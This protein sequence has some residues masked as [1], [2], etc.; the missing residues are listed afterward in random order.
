MESLSEL[1]RQVR[2]SKGLTLEDMASKTRIN[3]DFLEALE[4]GNFARLPDQVFAKGFV[5]AYARSLGLDEGEALR[6]FESAAGVFYEKQTETEQLRAKQVEEARRKRANRNVVI[7]AALLALLVLVLL[8]TRQQSELP[9][10]A[11]PAMSE[12]APA[13]NPDTTERWPDESDRAEGPGAETIP[14]LTL[15]DESLLPDAGPRQ[16][17]TTLSEQDGTSPVAVP[18]TDD[19]ASAPPAVD[20]DLVLG[21]GALELTWALVQVDSETPQEVL[22]RPGEKISWTARDRFTLTL[23]NA[24]EVQ[25]EL[26]GKTQGPFGPRGKVVRGIILSRRDV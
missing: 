6:L 21:L 23:G 4:A 25:V 22:L 7:A 18:T 5:R 24:G 9:P 26:N 15:A 16:G 11:V 12:P 17:E 19:H 8:I 3:L 2:E 10:P 20:H 14:P 1:F 13:P